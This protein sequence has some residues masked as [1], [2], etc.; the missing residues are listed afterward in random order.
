MLQELRRFFRR[1][2]A[3]P[4]KRSCVTLKDF[5]DAEFDWQNDERTHRLQFVVQFRTAKVEESG[6]ATA[7]LNIDGGGL[8]AQAVVS[9]DS[10]GTTV[11]LGNYFWVPDDMKRM[12]IGAAMIVGIAQ[13]WRVAAH[14]GSIDDTSLRIEGYFVGEGAAFAQAVAEVPP[15][16][17]AP[18][19]LRRTVVLRAQRQ[20]TLRKRPELMKA[21]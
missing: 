8:R 12:G 11:Y 9:E 14:G 21:W 17:G 19:E 16:K 1:S 20:L 6:Y 18:T 3:G 7:E 4:S 13:A 10:R 2:P 15:R 5:S